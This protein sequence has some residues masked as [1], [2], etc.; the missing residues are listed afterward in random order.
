MIGAARLEVPIYEEVE[1]DVNATGQAL[2]IVVAASISAGLGAGISIGPGTLILGTIGALVGW[3]VWAFLV[4][5]IGA[6]ALPEANT[7][8]DVMEIIRVL[9]FASTPGLLRILT[10][11]PYLGGLIGVAL[12]IWTIIA[13][14]IGVRQ[15]L[16]YTNTARAAL[17]VLIG[18][19]G[20]MLIWAMVAIPTFI[21]SHLFL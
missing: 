15:A 6:K 18:W 3:F 19:V 4:Y 14:V 21:F 11:I 10:G 7:K 13:M 2:A 16:D 9:G 5:V 1:H 20:F 17:V 12:M 8:S